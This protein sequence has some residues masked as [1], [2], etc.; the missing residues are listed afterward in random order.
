MPAAAVEA[1]TTWRCGERCVTGGRHTSELGGRRGLF[2]LFSALLQGRAKKAAK[3]A[4]REHKRV[5]SQCE[6]PFQ[7]PSFSIDG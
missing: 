2:A 1:V 5:S 6:T 3:E 4:R 7:V